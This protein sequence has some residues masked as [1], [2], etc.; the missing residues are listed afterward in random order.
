MVVIKKSNKR[1]EVL[2]TLEVVFSDVDALV[3]PWLFLVHN[4]PIEL[5][6]IFSSSVFYL[7]SF[8]KGDGGWRGGLEAYVSFCHGYYNI[9]SY[10]NFS[11]I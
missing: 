8:F 9:C 7:F 6:P 11:I 10:T 4:Q 5:L 1:I 3:L 2:G